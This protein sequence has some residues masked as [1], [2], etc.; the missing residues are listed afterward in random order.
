[1]AAEPFSESKPTAAQNAVEAQDSEATLI[2]GSTEPGPDHSPAACASE[3]LLSGASSAQR[4]KTDATLPRPPGRSR[5]RLERWLA[6]LGSCLRSA[7]GCDGI[8]NVRTPTSRDS[9]HRKDLGRTQRPKSIRG[10]APTADDRPT[11]E[12]AHPW[13]ESARKVP[14][15][16]RGVRSAGQES[17]RGP[18]CS[19]SR[20]S[21]RPLPSIAVRSNPEDRD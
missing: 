6:R 14:R 1:M 16:I 15:P 5:L 9:T 2:P 7:P 11:K 3:A 12:G 4:T 17:T 18:I 19:R 21:F 8:C 13:V 10:S 20:L